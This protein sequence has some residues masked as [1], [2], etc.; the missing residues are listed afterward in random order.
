[1]ADGLMSGSSRIEANVEVLY[2]S[3]VNVKGVDLQRG[4]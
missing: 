2:I 3:C 4:L 1:M